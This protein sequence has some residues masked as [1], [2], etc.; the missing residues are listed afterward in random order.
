M[1]EDTLGPSTLTLCLT[2]GVPARPLHRGVRPHQRGEFVEPVKLTYSIMMSRLC[3]EIEGPLSN[4]TTRL[5]LKAV[6]GGRAGSTRARP[7]PLLANHPSATWVKISG[8]MAG[9]RQW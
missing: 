7:D 3:G 5:D 9:P 8:G 1:A 4:R 6:S 2:I